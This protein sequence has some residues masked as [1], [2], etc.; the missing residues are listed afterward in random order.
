M[1][2]V[3]SCFLGGLHTFSPRRSEVICDARFLYCPWII[4]R[5]CDVLPHFPS[6]RP[7]TLH[8][9]RYKSQTLI[10]D[11]SSIYALTMTLRYLFISLFVGL[12]RLDNVYAAPSS[13]MENDLTPRHDISPRAPTCNTATNRACWTTS[14]AFNINTDYETSW[15]TTG[16][17]TRTVCT[18]IF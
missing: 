14:P 13:L 7:Q 12:I 5:V 17:T 3:V 18:Y 2:N 16:V 4:Y 9:Y 11:I 8:H 15:P 6:G 1:V 10:S